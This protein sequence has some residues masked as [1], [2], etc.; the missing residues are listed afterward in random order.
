MALGV[1]QWKTSFVD[2]IKL[3]PLNS[4]HKSLGKEDGEARLAL[5]SSFEA[6]LQASTQKLD[7]QERQRWV[8]IA[9]RLAIATILYNIVEGVVSILFGS[10]DGSVSSLVVLTLRSSP[11][12]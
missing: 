3:E 4:T 12:R 6:E 10:E 2:R 11:F 1:E 7:P 8:S 9:I 5:F